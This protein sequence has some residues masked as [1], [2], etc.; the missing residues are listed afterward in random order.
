MRVLTGALVLDLGLLLV[1]A[2]ALFVAGGVRRNL[3]QAFDL[4]CVAVLPLV[5][6]DLA[7]TVTVRAAGLAIAASWLL[8]ALSLGWMGALVALAIRPARNPGRAP[9]PPAEVVR[10]GRRV[11]A[12]FAVVAAAGAVLQVAWIAGHLESVKPMTSGEQAPA[13]ALPRIEAAGALGERV[14]LAASRGK[15]TVLDFWATWCKPCLAEMPRLD[16]IARAHPD[17]AVIAININD[18]A[19]AR[20]LFDQRGWAMTLVADDGDTGERYGVS[21]IP[22]TVILD[23]RGVVREVLRGARAD[24]A[25]VIEAIRA[26]E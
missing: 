23:R 17:V 14:T 9:S 22:H 16:R 21:A 5:V 2:L 1:G 26:S 8:R 18:P 13:I 3:G 25:T 10:R 11:G 15:V 19:A 4:A 7:A 24:L 20:A 6:V 12:A